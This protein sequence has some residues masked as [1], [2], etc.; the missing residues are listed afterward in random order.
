[1]KMKE[2]IDTTWVK[3]LTYYE[4]EFGKL[5]LKGYSDVDANRLLIINKEL[6]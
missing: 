5:K 2:D 4:K 1:M 3:S 6:K